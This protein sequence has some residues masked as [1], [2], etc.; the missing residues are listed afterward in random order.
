ML[1]YDP[2][3]GLI[4]LLLFFNARGDLSLNIFLLHNA[5]DIF[6]HF[7]LILLG[8]LVS[9]ELLDFANKFLDFLLEVLAD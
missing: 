6:A 4:D 1:L 8:Q 3:D 2:I 5:N 9:A 7:F